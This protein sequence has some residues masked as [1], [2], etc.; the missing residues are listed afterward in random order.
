MI[1]LTADGEGGKAFSKAIQLSPPNLALLEPTTHLLTEKTG[2]PVKAKQALSGGWLLLGVD[3]PEL[4]N[5]AETRLR[6]HDTVEAIQVKKV[7]PKGVGMPETYILEVA[8]RQDSKEA[9]IIDDKRSGSVAE[10]FRKLISELGR[11]LDLPLTAKPKPAAHLSIEI[12]LHELTLRLSQRLKD[13]P[14]V[15]E[16][17]NLNYI[18]TFQ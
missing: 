13:L 15:I 10:P 17:V 6:Q 18:T 2:I 3:L 1:K 11:Q 8:F 16:S 12:D 14:E 4:I 9:K 7:A 5:R